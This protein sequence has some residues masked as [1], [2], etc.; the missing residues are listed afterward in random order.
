MTATL[1]LVRF[2]RSFEA[3]PLG[4][5]LTNAV[6]GV[7]ARAAVRQV[8]RPELRQGLVEAVAEGDLL[9][10]VEG[11]DVRNMELPAVF[12]EVKARGVPI[13]L[14]FER[15]VLL[16]EHSF[17]RRPLGIAVAA[18]HGAIPSA[19]LGGGAGGDANYN[20]ANPTS[21]VVVSE[22]KPA[23]RAQYL[24]GQR[25]PAACS[26]ARCCSRGLAA[27]STRSVRV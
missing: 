27:S 24:D 8:S 10:E 5:S 13:R 11:L 18:L 6:P 3:L 17:V 12:A 4:I 21:G 20:G 2:S 22:V 23:F 9:V 25:M 7:G 14:G 19:S 1:D 16:F 15:R 26:R